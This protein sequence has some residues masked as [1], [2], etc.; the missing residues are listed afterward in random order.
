MSQADGYKGEL[1]QVSAIESLLCHV[2]S[3]HGSRGEYGLEVTV[4]SAVMLVAMVAAVVACTSTF[5]T[6]HSNGKCA[7]QQSSA[8]WKK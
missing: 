5:N 8:F 7:L 6:L 3:V 4:G 1:V 2:H